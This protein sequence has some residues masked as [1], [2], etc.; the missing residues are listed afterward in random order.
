[1]L[2]ILLVFQP[3]RIKLLLFFQLY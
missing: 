2:G 1:M 3:D